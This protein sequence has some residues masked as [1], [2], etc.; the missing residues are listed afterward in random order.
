MAA[1]PRL[2]HPRHWPT[3]ILMG[4]LWLIAQTPYRIQLATG[5]ALGRLAYHAIRRRRHVAER[6]LALCFPELSPS[7]RRTL[8]RRHFESLGMGIVELPMSWWA[9]AGAIDRRLTLEGLEHLQAVQARGQGAILL[10]GHFTS[11]DICG[12][13]FAPHADVDILF[14]PQDNPVIEHF[15]GGHRKRRFRHAI[16]RHDIRAMVRALR[17]GRTIWYAPDQNYRGRNSAL[18]PFFGHP[19]PTNTGTTRLARMTGAAVLPFYMERRLETGQ[20][21]IRIDPPLDDF[22]SD[23]PV[24][25]TAR[26]NRILEAQ[27]RCCPEQYLWVHERFKKRPAPLPDVYARGQPS[28]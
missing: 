14:R 3:W 27:I 22:P 26:Q 1:P 17:Q 2:I 16:E 28:A 23:D 19:A 18:V 21:L 25:D 4:V 24:A 10:S 11:I 13:L 7:E 6:N 12:R 15:L 20:Y 5:R 8:L 9:P